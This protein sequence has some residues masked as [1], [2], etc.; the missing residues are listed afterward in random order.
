LAGQL[1]VTGKAIEYGLGWLE[2]HG[3]ITIAREKD[4]DILRIEFKGL[5][6]SNSLKKFTTLLENTLDEITA[7]RD[8]YS[9]TN[10]ENLLR[11]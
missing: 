10:S 3:D 8:Y 7:F 1:G 5:K 6:D 2:A 9:R 11:N 4:S